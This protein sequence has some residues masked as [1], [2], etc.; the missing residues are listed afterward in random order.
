MF[1][2]PYIL[3]SHLHGNDGMP[4]FSIFSQY[5]SMPRFRMAKVRWPPR[6]PWMR[7]RNTLRTSS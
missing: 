5:H 6:H 7:E 3:D 1:D 4:S 2:I